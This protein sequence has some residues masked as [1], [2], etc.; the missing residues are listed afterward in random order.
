MDTENIHVSLSLLTKDTG[1]PDIL[2]ESLKLQSRLPE[3]EKKKHNRT[4]RK[5]V[6]S[7]SQVCVCVF[8]CAI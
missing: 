7:E 1:K 4:K 6:S 3:D 8:V 2:P 5:R